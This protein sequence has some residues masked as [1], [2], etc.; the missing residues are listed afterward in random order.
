MQVKQYRQEN[1]R[2]YSVLTHWTTAGVLGNVTLYQPT[3]DHLIKVVTQ[4]CS[5]SRYQLP[6]EINK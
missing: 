5:S 1:D 2:D 3:V 4:D 6:W